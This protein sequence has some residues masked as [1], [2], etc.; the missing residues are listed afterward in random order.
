MLKID[1]IKRA[2]EIVN[3][4]DVEF[5]RDYEGKNLGYGYK[6]HFH[7]AFTKLL[8]IVEKF[9]DFDE[10]DFEHYESEVNNLVYN[11]DF[12]KMFRELERFAKDL[13]SEAKKYGKSVVGRWRKGG[14]YVKD[15]F[16]NQCL[17]LHYEC[18]EPGIIRVS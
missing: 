12:T 2:E 17:S 14:S 3:G 6:V 8:E 10:E 9:G 18:T 5:V 7:A 16:G 1:Q 13:D 4:E 15:D 11:Q